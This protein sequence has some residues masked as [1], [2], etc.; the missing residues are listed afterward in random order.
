MSFSV[1]RTEEEDPYY[2]LA[3]CH[4][5]EVRLYG[6]LIVGAHPEHG[7][8]FIY[9]MRWPFYIGD[10]GQD[11]SSPT[12]LEEIRISLKRKVA[13][14][15]AAG[16]DASTW[17]E[18]PPF[19]KNR[20]YQTNSNVKLTP[21]YQAY[22]RE[23][24]DPHCDLMIRGLS[25]MV[26]CGMLKSLGRAFVDT[27]C[28]EIYV[29]LEATLE[30]ILDRLRKNGNPNPSNRDASD[31]LLT[32]FNEAYRLDRY[33]GAFYDDRIKAVHPKSRFGI[34]R[35]TPLCVDDLYML[36][37]DLLRNFEFLITDVPNCYMTFQQDAL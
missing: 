12:I 4:S 35:F 32:A 8:V 6:S 9:P 29:A 5:E 3:W 24:I 19:L 17:E 7:K 34:A 33:Y 14:R 23:S 15:Y 28:L 20:P 27:A 11:L 25:H 16:R 2:E 22:L 30:I 1:T 21:Q 13:D 37:N 18:L 10:E 31:Y 36:Y 26:K